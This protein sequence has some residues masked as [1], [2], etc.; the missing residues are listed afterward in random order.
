MTYFL[1]GQELLVVAVRLPL[2]MKIFSLGLSEENLG[3][4]PF[5]V[6]KLGLLSLT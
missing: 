1:I 4:P 3:E 2:H 6:T 5:D